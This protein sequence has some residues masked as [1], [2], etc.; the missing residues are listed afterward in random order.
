[1]IQSKFIALFLLCAAALPLSAAQETSL[2][3]IKPNAVAAK[4]VGE[5]ITSFEE[6]GLSVT[7]LKMTQFTPKKAGQFYQ[8]HRERPFFKDVVDFMSSGPIVAIRVEGEQAVTKVRELLGAT[9]PKEAR[10]GTLRARF[11]DSLSENGT[12]GSDSVSSATRELAFFFG[13]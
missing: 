1:M 7:G 2:A 10:L 12:H 11:G 3:L 13:S 5:I 6:S 8:E 4:H 9:N